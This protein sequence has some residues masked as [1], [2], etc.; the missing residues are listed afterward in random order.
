MNL[1]T[2][3]QILKKKS[4]QKKMKKTNKQKIITKR[5]MNP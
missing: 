3:V 1:K 2:K 4:L 5:K